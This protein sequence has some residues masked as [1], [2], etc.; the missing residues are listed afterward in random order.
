[1]AEHAAAVSALFAERHG[2]MVGFARK[3]LRRFGIPQAWADPE[4]V[5]QI[6]ITSVLT[7]TEPVAQMRP[8]VFKAIENEVW[9]A[10][11]SYRNV[12]VYGSWDTDLRMEAA[13]PAADPLHAVDLRLDLDTALDALPPKQHRAVLCTK[14]L[15]LTRAETAQ[16]MGLAPG[17]VATHVSRAVATLKLTLGGALAVVPI[18]CAVQWL[19]S[20]SLPTEPAGVSSAVRTL[21]SQ[22]WW[23]ILVG[24]AAPLLRSWPL[25]S[26]GVEPCWG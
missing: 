14:V 1:M 3:R 9:H 15:G 23:W 10:A 24:M 8:Y 25:K 6:A 7:S 18:G 16:A 19:R 22:P 5:V 26:G 13:G 21:L 11:K 17:T 2:Q 12:Q 4:D 20:G